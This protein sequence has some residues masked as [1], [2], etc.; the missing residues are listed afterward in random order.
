MTKN[1]RVLSLI[2]RQKLAASL[3][4]RTNFVF[5][6]LNS[7]L[8]FILLVTVWQALRPE[9]FGKEIWSFY[10]LGSFIAAFNGESFY[11]TMSG[12]ISTGNL[13]FKLLRPFSYFYEQSAKVFA[14]AFLGIAIS[15]G[16]IVLATIFVTGFLNLNLANLLFAA[17][18]IFIGRAISLL[19]SFLAGCASFIWIN[20]D[21]FYLVL[22][23]CLYALYG[24]LIPFWLLGQNWQNLIN[25]FPFRHV[26]ATPVE[27]ALG[28]T[29]NLL[30]YFAGGL[31]WL[32]V[33]SL[34]SRKIWQ[35]VLVH[36]E[37]V[38]G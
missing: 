1:F 10:V 17:A 38:G 16:V 37:A 8:T 2:F 11:R 33:L 4:Y 31:F 32:I 15:S 25:I 21:P 6:I 26:V 35:K 3:E 28:R 23:V 12:D 9:D 27:I 18:F 24:L 22:D 34:T 36:Y 5:K 29:D 14:D 20:P 13:S 7:F 19:I 30:I